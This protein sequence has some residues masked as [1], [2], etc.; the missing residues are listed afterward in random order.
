M[1]CLPNRDGSVI[2]V[3]ATSSLDLL[4]TLLSLILSTVCCACSWRLHATPYTRAII[5]HP[6]NNRWG[7]LRFHLVC[8]FCFMHVYLMH[9]LC[10]CH[11]LWML[12]R[13]AALVYLRSTLV[14]VYMCVHSLRSLHTHLASPSPSPITYITLPSRTQK[15]QATPP[16]GRQAQC[17]RLGGGHPGCLQSDKLPVRLELPA[18]WE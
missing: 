15:S 9:H 18:G 5:P 2:Y 16:R 12:L 10:L 17:V 8:V 6:P 1:H 3:H 13:V 14:Q 7:G 11:H 4:G